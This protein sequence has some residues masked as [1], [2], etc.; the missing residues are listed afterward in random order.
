MPTAQHFQTELDGKLAVC[1]LRA[2]ATKVLLDAATYTPADL[3]K[4]NV[5]G[6]TADLIT[7]TSLEA[8][9]TRR[10]LIMKSIRARKTD[11]YLARI[12]T[13]CIHGYLFSAMAFETRNLASKRSLSPFK[14]AAE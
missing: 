5:G 9:Q 11:P 13:P 8:A 3:L 4:L 12:T 7:D 6:I 1:G 2:F 14:A 10:A